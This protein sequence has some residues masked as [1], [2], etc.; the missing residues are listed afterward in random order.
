MTITLAPRVLLE[1]SDRLW[2]ADDLTQEDPA[3]R[4]NLPS[5]LISSFELSQNEGTVKISFLS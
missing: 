1:K 4:E 5:F 3:K 2:N